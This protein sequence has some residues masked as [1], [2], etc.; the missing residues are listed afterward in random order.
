MEFKH[1]KNFSR[2]TKLDKKMYERV[3]SR[4]SELGFEGKAPEVSVF[5]DKSSGEGVT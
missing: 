2:R 3:V 5:E 1:M 4:W